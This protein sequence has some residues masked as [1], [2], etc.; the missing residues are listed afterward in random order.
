MK[1]VPYDGKL[2]NPSIKARSDNLDEPVLVE[3]NGVI[4]NGE[5]PIDQSVMDDY[6]VATNSN[7][8]EL[9]L[10]C[11]ET[12]SSESSETDERNSNDGSSK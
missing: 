8:S 4:G 12:L 3:A 5:K 9:E 11:T 2:S 7:Y 1:V 6:R 10:G